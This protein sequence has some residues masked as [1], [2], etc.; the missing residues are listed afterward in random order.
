MPERSE[1]LD[2]ARLNHDLCL[3]LAADLETTRFRQWVVT[4]AFYAA[5]HLV[6]ARL[7]D[8]NI[9]PPFHS[10]RDNE[11]GRDQSLRQVFADYRLLKDESRDARYSCK[12]P[13]SAN[14][15]LQRVFPALDRISNHVQR[16][17]I[18]PALLR[19]STPPAPVPEPCDDTG[20]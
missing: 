8:R 20:E 18:A 14:A 13:L 10:S 15:I 2:Q 9:H 3:E 12:P 7:A 1:H 6:D 11:V 16:L 5:I 4:T 17:L 19:T